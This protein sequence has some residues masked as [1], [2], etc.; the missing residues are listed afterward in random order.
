VLL[1][2]FMLLVIPFYSTV[3]FLIHLDKNRIPLHD[4]ALLSTRHTLLLHSFG[5]DLLTSPTALVKANISHN[6]AFS[7]LASRG[8]EE[9]L[10]LHVHHFG[11]LLV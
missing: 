6:A 8:V 7:F 9:V 4:S 5:D 10:V 1:I 2:T 3:L 11:G